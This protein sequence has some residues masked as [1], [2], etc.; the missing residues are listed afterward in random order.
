M[1][2]ISLGGSK[3]HVRTGWRGGDV[4]KKSG[5]TWDKQRQRA[6]VP[7]ILLG[8][9]CDAAL[10]AGEP[11]ESGA[12]VLYGSSHFLSRTSTL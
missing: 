10:L 6:S 12:D 3:H 1:P 9:A 2:C 7:Q 5:S 11:R 4:K 8:D